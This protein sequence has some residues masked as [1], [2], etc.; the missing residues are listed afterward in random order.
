MLCV[1]EQLSSPP[2]ASL[3]RVQE[4]RY[5]TESDRRLTDDASWTRRRY[6]RAGRRRIPPKQR[7]VWPGC[8]DG[9]SFQRNNATLKKR[10]GALPA[11]PRLCRTR[12]HERTA[13]AAIPTQAPAHRASTTWP[14]TRVGA[15]A[16]TDESMRAQAAPAAT[17][18]L[19]AAAAAAAEEAAVHSTSAAETLPT[20]RGAAFLHPLDTEERPVGGAVPVPTAIDHD[21]TD[22]RSGQ[23]S[24]QA[25][26]V[27]MLGDDVLDVGAHACFH[28]YIAT[29]TCVHTQ[30]DMRAHAS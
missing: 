18:D 28:T 11:R 8:L 7:H 29:C 3:S 13:T 19:A 9:G 30:V 16:E 6:L 25:S 20:F 15:A 27:D 23:E 1:H 24:P 5:K 22:S 12:G 17:G 10:R 14:A 26:S 2:P 4:K 21:E